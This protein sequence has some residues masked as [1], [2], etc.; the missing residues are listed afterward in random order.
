MP[1]YVCTW[2]PFHLGM[3]RVDCILFFFI[4]S[5]PST[6]LLLSGMLSQQGIIVKKGNVRTIRHVDALIPA[7]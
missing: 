1:M 7:Q 4:S 6:P 2:M 3:T 5:I